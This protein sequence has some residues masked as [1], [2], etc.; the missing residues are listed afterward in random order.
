[1]TFRRITYILGVGMED[2]RSPSGQ[3]HSRSRSTR[4]KAAYASSG[5]ICRTCPTS[6]CVSADLSVE[7]WC[8]IALQEP[9]AMQTCLLRRATSSSDQE[10]RTS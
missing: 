6:P 8:A 2:W 9:H 3:T 4:E 1:M 5:G 10:V 7:F